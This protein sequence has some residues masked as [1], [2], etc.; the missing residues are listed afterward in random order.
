MEN[1][2]RFEFPQPIGEA[3]EELLAELAE[4]PFEGFEEQR[5][6]LV[7]Y[8]PEASCTAEV[9]E[10]LKELSLQN[11]WAS[12]KEEIIAPQ[13]WNAEWEKQ[14]EPVI[15][16][17]FCAIRATFHEPIPGIEHEI[18]ITP[19]MSF[20][21]GHHATT[22]MMVEAM[23]RLDFSDKTVLDYGSGTSVLAILAVKLGATHVDAVDI[24]PWAYENSLEN[25]AINWVSAYIQVIE[26]DWSQVPPNTQYD[27][28]LANIN[29]HIILGSMADMSAQLKSGGNLLCS[30]FLEGDVELVTEA[31]AAAGIKLVNISAQEQWRCLAFVKE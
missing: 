8:I 5:D 18:V 28:I 16:G 29:R 21:T 6:C 12:V 30:G 27:I 3:Q 14:Y 1:Y 10:Y 22:Y 24:D 25:A 2:L 15:V 13:N 7:A 9:R 11:N 20:G 17:D 26:G 31:A 19:K 23:S 4:W